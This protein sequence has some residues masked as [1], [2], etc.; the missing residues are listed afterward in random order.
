MPNFRHTTRPIRDA[1]R[2]LSERVK[3]R[4]FWP[5]SRRFDKGQGQEK[6]KA[7]AK[8]SFRFQVQGHLQSESQL[9]LPNLHAKGALEK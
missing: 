5:V 8:E 1:R 9:L 3:V 7:K 6:G 2:R 4:G